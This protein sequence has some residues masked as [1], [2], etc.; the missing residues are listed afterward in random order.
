ME[1]PPTT[2]APKGPD[3]PS[4]SLHNYRRKDNLT[5]AIILIAI[6]VLLLANNLF[7]GFDF[8]DY[9]PL[10]LIATGVSL[11]LRSRL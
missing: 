11:L 8:S 6:G 2:E 5:G 10:I 9:W 3:S 1:Q 7:P 4:S